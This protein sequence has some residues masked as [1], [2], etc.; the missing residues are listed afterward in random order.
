V[1]D[2]HKDQKYPIRNIVVDMEFTTNCPKQMIRLD[3]RGI[4]S[5]CQDH[6]C[7]RAHRE[8]DGYITLTAEEITFVR[9]ILE[10]GRG[11]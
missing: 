5:F 9:K 6:A 10:A 3:R 7:T 4:F 11:T 2:E 1:V 8:S